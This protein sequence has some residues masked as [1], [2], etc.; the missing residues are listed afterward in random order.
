[1]RKSVNRVRSAFEAK[2]LRPTRRYGYLPREQQQNFLGSGNKLT[3]LSDLYFSFFGNPEIIQRI[4]FRCVSRLL[5]SEPNSAVIDLGCGY[6]LLS[7]WLASNGF[8]AIGVDVKQN[9]VKFAKRTA[10]ILHIRDKASYIVASV[11]NLPF[12]EKSFDYSFCLDVIEHVPNDLVALSEVSRILKP[13]GELILTTPCWPQKF[14][15]KSG[16][17]LCK[18]WGH[19][20]GGYALEDLKQILKDRGLEIVA[21]TFW[22]KFFTAKVFDLYFRL[23]WE[24]YYRTRL[25]LGAVLFPF[26]YAFCLLDDVFFRKSQGNEFA[27]KIVR[28]A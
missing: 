2:F 14:R 20:R 8:R 3:L 27:L 10:K 24:R 4:R 28:Q 9:K 6:G 13:K 17:E 15:F 7:T 12:R 19:V 5:D 11:C 16:T 23:F 18:E 22:L 25:A 21:L 1:M 26:M